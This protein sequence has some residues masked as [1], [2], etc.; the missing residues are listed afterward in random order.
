MRDSKAI[1]RAMSPEWRGWES[2]RNHLYAVRWNGNLY[3]VKETPREYCAGGDDVLPIALDLQ[4]M[5]KI[6]PKMHGNAAQLR[7]PIDALTSVL[8]E[9]C[10]MSRGK[11]SRMKARLDQVG[12]AS[13][14]E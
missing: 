10:V 14:I 6:L 13:F 4:V 5:Q 8:P 12:F 9:S 11:L 7:G 2:R 3:P 1:V